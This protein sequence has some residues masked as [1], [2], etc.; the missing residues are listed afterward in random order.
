MELLTPA[1]TMVGGKVV[2]EDGEIT[3]PEGEA[4]M[5]RGQTNVVR[6]RAEKRFEG[7]LT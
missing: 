6:L 7:F 5:C 3:A 1:F 4:I 2:M